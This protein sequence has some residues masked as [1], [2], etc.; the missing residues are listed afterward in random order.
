[1]LGNINIYVNWHDQIHLVIVTMRN[2]SNEL[3]L[4]HDLIVFGSDQGWE[5]FSMSA[6]SNCRIFQI[7]YTLPFR[8]TM[9]VAC[10]NCLCQVAPAH[11]G[12]N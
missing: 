12:Q 2:V 8:F 7:S 6:D 10:P 3:D 11:P 5:P 4:S 9:M 1:M